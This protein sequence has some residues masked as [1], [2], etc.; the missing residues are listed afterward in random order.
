VAGT[1]KN[2]GGVMNKI[3]AFVLTVL[4]FIVVG[5]AVGAL[6]AFIGS[7]FSEIMRNAQHGIGII[8]QGLGF[9]LFFGY[10]FG[11]AFALVAGLV[12]AILGIWLRW[13][14]F[15]AP[16]VGAVVSTLA[17]AALVPVIFQMTAEPSSV[18][19]FFPTCLFATFICWFL[20]RPI[21]RRTWPSV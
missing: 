13:N 7:G 21:V 15:L 11:W 14:N 19:W 20:T 17:G 8:F 16:V 18:T 5:P 3:L 2:K 12:V 4:I 6:A 9:V 10:I 1:A